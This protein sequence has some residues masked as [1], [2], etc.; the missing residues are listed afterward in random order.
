MSR[1][2]VHDCLQAFAFGRPV[3]H[4]NW[5]CPVCQR[6]LDMSARVVVAILWRDAMARRS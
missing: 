4:S 5:R 6:S 1:F 3:N 2:D